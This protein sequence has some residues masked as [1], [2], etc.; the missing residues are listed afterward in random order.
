MFLCTSI[1]NFD[2]HALIQIIEK[3]ESRLRNDEGLAKN[4]FNVIVTGVL[5][6]SPMTTKVEMQPLLGGEVTNRNGNHQSI[7]RGTSS[8]D[9]DIGLSYES[10]NKAKSYGSVDSR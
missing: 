5:N 2:R 9:N 6:V 7:S 10:H 1:V 3:E 8:D 4:G